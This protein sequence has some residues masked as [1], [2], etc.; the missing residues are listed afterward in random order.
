MKVLLLGATGRTGKI[1]LDKAL[2][3]GH[4][5]NCLVR[6]PEMINNE[7]ERIKIFKGSPEKIHDLEEAMKGCKAVVS[8]LNISRKSDFPWAKVITPATFLSDVI[9]NVI[10]VAKKTILQDLLLVL[11]GEYQI[12]KMI[13]QNGLSGSLT[14]VI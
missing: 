14:T 7:H 10:L 11:L 6:N 5:I 12:L 4:E 1:I 9:N 13:Y 8:V 2:R 3:N